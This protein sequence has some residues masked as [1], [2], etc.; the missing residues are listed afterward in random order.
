MQKQTE[1]NYKKAYLALEKIDE[2]VST[3]AG[4]EADTWL[5]LDKPRG[6]IATQV[7]AKQWAELIMEIYRITHPL[8][9]SCCSKGKHLKINTKVC[10]ACDGS[11]QRITWIDGEKD[12]HTCGR[13]GG[14]GLIIL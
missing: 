4:A 3:G 2:L 5:G 11:G 7:M 12:M 6:G 13:C 1:A 14:R 9:H 10:G 8:L